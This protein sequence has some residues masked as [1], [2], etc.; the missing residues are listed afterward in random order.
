MGFHKL[1]AFKDA[2]EIEENLSM[3]EW[4]SWKKLYVLALR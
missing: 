4:P 2:A 3:W 1:K